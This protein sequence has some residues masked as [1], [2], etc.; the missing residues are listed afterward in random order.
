VKLIVPCAKADATIDAQA[1]RRATAFTTLN[2]PPLQ[3][4]VNAINCYLNAENT[5]P[6]RATE[7]NPLRG[8]TSRLRV[9][10][11]RTRYE[12]RGRLFKPSLRPSASPRP[13]RLTG[14]P[15]GFGITPTR[16]SP[17]CRVRRSG[18]SS[19]PDT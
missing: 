7:K 4:P 13:L 15:S 8:G 14:W 16:L 9:S 12:G 10:F 18:G 11:S 5:E 3:A 19:G 2:L 6:Q 1:K 17:R